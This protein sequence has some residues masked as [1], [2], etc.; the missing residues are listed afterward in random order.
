MNSVAGWVYDVAKKPNR[1]RFLWSV[2]GAVFW[3][4]GVAIMVILAPWLDKT[5]GLKL[6]I[7]LPVRLAVA[8]VLL[9][10]WHTNGILDY[11]AI[12]DDQRLTDSI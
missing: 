4:G 2:A 1:R 9:A 6:S 3:Y 7:I 5:W 11:H 12:L 8:I 10:D